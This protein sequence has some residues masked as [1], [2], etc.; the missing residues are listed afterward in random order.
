MLTSWYCL[1]L[2]LAVCQL[3]LRC[4]VSALNLCSGYNFAS[5]EEIQPYLEPTASGRSAQ[6]AKV[7]ADRLKSVVIIGYPELSSRADPVLELEGNSACVVDSRPY[8]SVVT[9]S[10]D[11]KVIGHYRKSFL[12][13]TDETWANE[14]PGFRSST[15]TLGPGSRAVKCTNAICMDINPKGFLQWDAF[16]FANHVLQSDVELVVVSMAWLS[17][18]SA[19]ELMTEDHAPDLATLSYWVQRF[20]PVLEQSDKEITVIFANRSGVEG[21]ACYAGSST[22]MRI[23]NGK[24]DVWGI[25]GKG[26]ESCLKVDTAQVR[27]ASIFDTVRDLPAH[28]NSL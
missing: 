4:I 20:K 7:I 19:S 6:W 11:G 23:G 3:L 27:N 8:N 16:E 22:V 28:F 1:S 12:Y 13:Y 9:I 14:G 24:A 5:L 18:L 2:R 17:S 26:K 15:V 21:T 10:P 25:I